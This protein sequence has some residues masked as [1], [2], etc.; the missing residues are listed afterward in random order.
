MA[1]ENVSEIIDLLVE[2]VTSATVRAEAL[3]GI[4]THLAERL[5]EM[6]S[7]SHQHRWDILDV[8]TPVTYRPVHPRMDQKRVITTVLVRC[9]DCNLPATVELDGTWTMEQI[10]RK[11]IG[12]G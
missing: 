5:D 8:Y 7:H 1:E 6:A 4:V 10:T 2:G 9:P 11:A 12:D 3:S